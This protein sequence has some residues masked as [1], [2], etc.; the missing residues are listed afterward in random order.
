MWFENLFDKIWAIVRR[1]TQLPVEAY[2]KYWWLH[3][4]PPWYCLVN[5]VLRWQMSL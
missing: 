5:V 1:D 3:C 4:A 2:R